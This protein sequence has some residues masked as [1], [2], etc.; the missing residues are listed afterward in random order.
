MSAPQSEHLYKLCVMGEGA[1]G[2]TTLSIQ[3]TANRFVDYYDPTIEDT[4]RK[5]VVIDDEACLLEI[6]DTAG[7]DQFQTLRAQWIRQYDS[8]LIVYSITDRGSFEGMPSFNKQILRAKETDRVPM[9]LVGNKCDLESK[10]QVQFQEGQALAKQLN[11]E[12]RETSAKTRYNVEDA[13][14]SAVRLI[15]LMFPPKEKDK[16]KQRPCLLL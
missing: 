7:Q 5:Q 1:V 11:A 8:F 16:K 13:F 12:F 10:R 14:Y 6:L 2:K 15:W 3:F 4:Y 9:I